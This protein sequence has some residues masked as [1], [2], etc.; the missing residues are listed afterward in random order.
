W[1][2]DFELKDENHVLEKPRNLHLR[3]HPLTP[4]VA[5]TVCES[6]VDITRMVQTDEGK[7]GN[8]AV[9]IPTLIESTSE[10]CTQFTGILEPYEDVPFIESSEKLKVHSSGFF[11]EAICIRH[12]GDIEDIIILNDPENQKPMKVDKYGIETDALMAVLRLEKGN[13]IKNYLVK[14]TYLSLNGIG[15]AINT[16]L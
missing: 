1:F 5:A 2:A 7:T 16:L 10:G 11:T 15:T 9:W 8:R 13:L 14:G 6:W 3:Y 12:G 4:G